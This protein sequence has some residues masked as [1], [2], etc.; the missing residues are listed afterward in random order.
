MKKS[1]LIIFILLYAQHA[2]SQN[3]FGFSYYTNEKDSVV[4]TRVFKNSPAEKSGLKPGDMLNFINDIPLAFKKK[5]LLAKVLSEAPNTNN[6]LRFYR[7]PNV[8]ETYIDKVPLS[9]F[10]FICISGDCNNGD[11]VVES[12]MGYTIKGKCK[13]NQINGAVEGFYENG[14]LYF[15]GNAIKNKFEG[16]GTMYFPDQSR[17]E[18]NLSNNERHGSGKFYYSNG[19]YLVGTWQNN[20]LEGEVQLKDANHQLKAK[21]TYLKG[22]LEKETLIQAQSN[23]Q[24]NPSQSV[25]VKTEKKITKDPAINQAIMDKMYFIHSSGSL[26]YFNPKYEFEPMYQKAPFDK[27]DMKEMSSY[28]YLTNKEAEHILEE[29]TFENYPAFY[30]NQKNLKEIMNGPFLNLKA[31]EVMPFKMDV[32]K[33]GF[34]SQNEYAILFISTSENNHAPNELLA[35][36]GYGF[37][38]IVAKENI[39]ETPS[40]KYVAQNF[41]LD[42]YRQKR[43]FKNWAEKKRAYLIDMYYLYENFTLNSYSSVGIQESLNIN[44]SELQQLK[45]WC[46]ISN[47]PE[48]LNTLT[49]VKDAH[50][51]AKLIDAVVY[52]IYNG[53]YYMPYDE[54]RHLEYAYQPK[55]SNGWYFCTSPSIINFNPANESYRQ[56]KLATTDAAMEQ[57]NRE[58]AA[59]ESKMQTDALAKAEWSEKNKFKGVFIIHYAGNLVNYDTSDDEKVYVISIFG[60]SNQTLTETDELILEEK[61]ESI[62]WKQQASQFK[63]NMNESEAINLLTDTK[64]FNRFSIQTNFSYTLPE[65]TSSN[66]SE[67]LEKNAAAI[68]EKQREI[69]KLS[70]ELYDTGAQQ[71]VEQLSQDMTDILKESVQEIKTQTTVEV[72][73][74]DPSDPKYQEI[75]DYVGLQG[76]TMTVL[77]LNE[78]GTYK[79]MIQFF[80]DFRTLTFEK[81]KVRIIN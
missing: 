42:D 8:K 19:D 62:G 27:A 76:K 81:V 69:D 60:P 28:L 71:K 56:S 73:E 1:I 77:K 34:Y 35:D 54:N 30:K 47:A 45:D 32:S 23:V 44:D 3:V 80:S 25:V 26:R 2:I 33:N 46:D 29:C 64:G 17:F 41:T 6:H 55:N 15:K 40:S 14:S 57:Y 37:F 43:G 36:D 18:G 63:Q 78:D 16:I 21:R 9:S 24:N 53:V 48:G 13:E 39:S 50:R 7:N 31:Y 79:G 4:V 58:Q 65:R 67:E 59:R 51:N 11:C 61:Y 66:Y 49:K 38:I 22:T 68:K 5:E 52:E 72:I 10:E 20:F 74:V 12:A 75:K 70:Q